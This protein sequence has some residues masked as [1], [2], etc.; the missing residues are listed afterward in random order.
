MQP[1]G[2]RLIADTRSA[3]TCSESL[4]FRYAKVPR[5]T[6]EVSSRALGI[7]DTSEGQK[8]SP[9]GELAGIFGEVLSVR[10][11]KAS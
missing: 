2:E 6:M 7:S 1:L 11:P 8:K 9:P 5:Q 3:L 4:H 10:R